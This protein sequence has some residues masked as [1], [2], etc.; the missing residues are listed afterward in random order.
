MPTLA[1]LIH[2][3]TLQKDAT[4]HGQPGHHL[5]LKGTVSHLRQGDVKTLRH[6][7]KKGAIARGTLRVQAKVGHRTVLDEQ[8]LDVHPTHIADAVCIREEM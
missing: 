2:N 6:T 3:V 1:L 5:C 4:T 7:L 8:N